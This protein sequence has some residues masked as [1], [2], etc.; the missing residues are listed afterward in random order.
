MSH[1]QLFPLA[2][3][4][5]PAHY[6]QQVHD[7]A[8]AILL[9]SSQPESQ[10]GRFDILSAWPLAQLSPHPTESLD[11]FR[12]RCQSL[13]KQLSICQTPDGLELPFTGG[14]IGYLTYDFNHLNQTVETE[15]L[16]GA[17]V[18]LYNWAVISDHQQKQSWLMCHCSVTTER[19]NE[20][21]NLFTT[22][23]QSI[24][25]NT[26]FSLTKAFAARINAQ[27]Y[28]N[29]LKRVYNYITAGDCYQVNYT[30]RFSSQYSGDAWQAYSSLRARCPTPFASFI[31]VNSQ[32]AIISLSPERLIQVH[33]RK[34]ES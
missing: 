28:Q 26:P 27:R 22:N 19:C 9:D 30:Q 24:L 33:Q 6:F 5:N 21:L 12:Q 25:S 3:Q 20:L 31:R 17:T 29:D 23:F 1:C 4:P 16:A 13:V 18:G 11:T 15:G 2:Y 8:G 34:V 32:Q 7:Q 14:L 10:R